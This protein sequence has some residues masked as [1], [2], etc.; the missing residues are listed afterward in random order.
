MGKEM[1]NCIITDSYITCFFI[2]VEHRHESSPSSR[3]CCCILL[4]SSKVKHNKFPMLAK[5]TNFF[6]IKLKYGGKKGK[7]CIEIAAVTIYRWMEKITF[8]WRE[9]R[10]IEEFV[11]GKTT[12]FIPMKNGNW[13]WKKYKKWC[14][15]ELKWAKV[16]YTCK[17]A[18]SYKAINHIF[19]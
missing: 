1:K 12:F 18:L 17:T 14:K 19:W 8:N 10:K 7:T 11:K 5:K 9:R 6:E 2:L 15:I 4:G 3:N 16:A 13:L